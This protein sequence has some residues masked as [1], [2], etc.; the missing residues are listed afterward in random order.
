[1]SGHSHPYY[2]EEKAGLLIWTDDRVKTEEKLLI[3]TTT[4][5]SAGA[6]P[7]E[8]PEWIEEDTG[9]GALR[10]ARAVNQ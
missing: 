8:G 4:V 6:M 2:F 10:T 5:P 1:V 7:K 3:Q 9:D